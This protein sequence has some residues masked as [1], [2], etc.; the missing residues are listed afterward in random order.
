M[1]PTSLMAESFLAEADVTYRGDRSAAQLCRAVVNDDV[2]SLEFHLK[3]VKDDALASYRFDTTSDA[4]VGSVTCNG[5][6]LLTFADEIGARNISGYL[7][8]GRVIIEEVVV[9]GRR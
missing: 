2:A 4:I 7:G 5:M 8:E 3:R 6:E 9:V 1:L